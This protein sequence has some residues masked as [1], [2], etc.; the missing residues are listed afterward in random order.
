MIR[1]FDH[2]VWIGAGP[3]DNFVHF[4]QQAKAITLVDADESNCLLLR[5]RFKS[6]QNLTVLHA[7]IGDTTGESDWFRYNLSQLSAIGPASEQLQSLYPGLR[8]VEKTTKEVLSLSMLLKQLALSGEQNALVLD[9]PASAGP[10]LQNLFLAACNPFFDIKLVGPTVALYE[11]ASCQ[12]QLVDTMQ[13]HGYQLVATDDTDPDF[14]LLSFQQNPLWQ[15]LQREKHETQMLRQQLAEACSEQSELLEKLQLEQELHQEAKAQLAKV[16]AWFQDRKKQ[17]EELEQKL[18]KTT[19][20]LEQLK[21]HQLTQNAL[22]Q[23]QNTLQELFNRQSVQLLQSTN[24]LG[25]HVSKTK[26]EQQNTMQSF[27]LLQQLMQGGEQLLNLDEWAMQADTLQKLTQ[28]VLANSFDLIIEFGS[29]QSTL[30]IAKT[31]AGMTKPPRFLSLEQS[32]HYF[33]KLQHR[34]NRFNLSEF[35]ELAHAAVK[36]VELRQD[37]KSVRVQEFYSCNDLLSG[38]SEEWSE[39]PGV[40]LVVVDGPFSDTNDGLARYAALPVVESFFPNHTLHVVLD[41]TKREGEKQVL[42]Q[43][44]SFCE[45]RGRA[46]EVEYWPSQKGAAL[47]KIQSLGLASL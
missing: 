31:L 43:W 45:Q 13:Q 18:V 8:L 42:Q 28:H 26:L 38:L 7:L 33:E 14:P 41:D 15:H 30:V 21:S 3:F 6:I 17:A 22:E 25:Q 1:R 2:L 34:I 24:A 4:L 20:D 5:K 29:G 32:L 12:K 19:E 44:Q 35:V 36:P 23:L 11:G 39:K 47:L 10:L 16:Q 40:I 46:T 37:Q 27:L 9:C